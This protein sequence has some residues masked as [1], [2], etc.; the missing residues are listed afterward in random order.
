MI[1]P[2]PKQKKLR[3]TDTAN[4]SLLSCPLLVHRWTTPLA[5]KLLQRPQS[6][7]PAAAWVALCQDEV[8]VT[9][10]KTIHTH[11][12]DSRLSGAKCRCGKRLLAKAPAT[13]QQ[14]L[15]DENTNNMFISGQLSMGNDP[16]QVLKGLPQERLPFEI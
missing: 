10:P 12:G 1:G 16:F 4:S 2:H 13:N 11:H 3:A 15:Y 5:S 14:E 6:T 8:F 9:R 7:R